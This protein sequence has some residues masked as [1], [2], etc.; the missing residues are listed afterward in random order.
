MDLRFG[1]PENQVIWFYFPHI[2]TQGNLQQLQQG[3]PRGVA[4]NSNNQVH[5][6]P[7]VNLC[8]ACQA[9]SAPEPSSCNPQSYK[10]VPPAPTDAAPAPLTALPRR[11]LLTPRPFAP[12]L[13]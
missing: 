8:L 4:T 5:K 9:R 10:S 6:C 12:R 2:Q 3:C 11:P 7:S 13:P 1:S